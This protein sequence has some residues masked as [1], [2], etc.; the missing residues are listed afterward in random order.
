MNNPQY[1][2]P[3]IG[4]QLQR[5]SQWKNYD[6]FL[7]G[8]KPNPSGNGGTAFIGFTRETKR[9]GMTVKENHTYYVKVWGNDAMLLQSM[10]EYNKSLKDSGQKTEVFMMN[11]NAILDHVN[12]KQGETQYGMS[13]RGNTFVQVDPKT[14]TVLQTAD[15]FAAQQ[16]QQQQVA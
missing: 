14:Y 2:K 4:T 1:A 6:G 12:A 8:F 7:N 13:L 9:Q 3:V 11:F 10:A 5:P 16:Q 15:N